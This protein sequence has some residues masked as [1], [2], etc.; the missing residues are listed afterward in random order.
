M[1]IVQ[2]V[3]V[4]LIGT[5]L[6]VF[7]QNERKEYGL[8][9]ALITGGILLLAII[10][11][12][13]GLFGAVNK[14]L[15]EYGISLSYLTLMLKT[16]GIAYLCQFAVALCKDAGQNGIAAKLEIGG[17]VLLLACAMPAM[18]G[19]MEIGAELISNLAS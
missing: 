17:R 7:L 9:C 15:T 19:L 8:I 18:A 12:L 16:I 14:L 5:A 13:S 1:K 11:E 6:T 2:L 4:A 10:G 3:T